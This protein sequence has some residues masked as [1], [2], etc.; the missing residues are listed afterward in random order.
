MIWQN[1][2]LRIRTLEREILEFRPNTT[3]ITSGEPQPIARQE[4]IIENL[5]SQLA[6][7]RSEISATTFLPGLTP[8]PRAPSDFI[9]NARQ[10]F[11]ESN[12]FTNIVSH[13]GE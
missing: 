11:G 7:I 1:N 4:R 13:R 6:Q 3:W 8:R 5:E 2:N 9:A 10:T 12:L